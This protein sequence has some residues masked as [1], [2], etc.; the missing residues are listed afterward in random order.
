MKSDLVTLIISLFFLSCT[1]VKDETTNLKAISNVPFTLNNNVIQPLA[2]P[3]ATVSTLAGSTI[4][5]LVDGP[6]KR[7]EYSYPYGIA[8]TTGGI[9]FVADFNNNCI[10]KITSAGVVTTIA[11]DGTTGYADG[12]GASAKFNHPSSIA[13]NTGGDI[14]VADQSN[15][16][17]R[18]VTQA[19][20]VTTVAG[21]TTPGY[22]NGSVAV[23]R[24][25]TPSG[26]TVDAT[27]NIL[28]TEW[29]NHT[30]RKIST[31][32][33][34]ST[35]AGGGTYGYAN[36][37]GTSALF[38]SP[39]SIDKDLSGNFFV[40]DANNSCIR[41]ITSTGVVTTLSGSPSMVGYQDGTLS[42]AKFNAMYALRVD[43][44]QNI[45]VSDISSGITKIR[46]ISLSLNQV[47]TLTGAAGYGYLD[48]S[49]SVAKFSTIWGITTDGSN[50]II[51]SEA[52]NY[53]RKISSSN[54]V[55]TL[56]GDGTSGLQDGDLTT[57]L[58]KF[59]K[60]KVIIFDNNG[61]YLIGDEGNNRVRRMTKYGIVTTL[62]VIVTPAGLAIDAANNIYVS[63]DSKIS[64]ITPSGVVSIYAGTSVMGFQDGPAATA[65][66]TRP[67]GLLFDASGNLLVA[68][69]QNFCIRL[70]ST[71]GIVSVIAGYPV[72]ITSLVDG[73]GTSARFNDPTTLCFDPQG[74]I[75]ISDWINKSLRKMDYTTRY[76]S[77]IYTS[78]FFI[79]TLAA[80]TTLNDIVFPTGNVVNKFVSPSSSVII[81][82]T[83][84]AGYFDGAASIAQFNGPSG[85]VITKNRN[86]ILADYNNNCIRKISGNW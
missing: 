4:A 84:T 46:K 58:A 32:G 28:V 22:V 24:F 13:L 23:A 59:N 70:I 60:P 85:L 8:V 80:S 52:G 38:N 73:Y 77:T 49:T 15:H 76:V 74:N 11:G 81:A 5:G 18:K 45:L 64:K 54:Q 14:L 7:P 27:G 51:L 40:I 39:S 57:P 2:G 35:L 47:S 31:T 62:P 19:G 66:F 29:G 41:K 79:S 30:I 68:D 61:D 33:V 72:A 3:S 86:I 50:N 53:I 69:E 78:N 56:S 1:K 10:R 16:L 34:V 44:Q 9:I 21:N 42:T 75:L 36:G 83:G 17:I 67:T 48:G 65:K 12:V 82:G 20:I 43:G 71:S 37:T 55:T 6:A 25:N 26:I 63:D